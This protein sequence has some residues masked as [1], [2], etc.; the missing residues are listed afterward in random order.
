MHKNII[1]INRYF[2]KKKPKNRTRNLNWPYVNTIDR[3]IE[4][5]NKTKSDSWKQKSV[6]SC[7]VSKVRFKKVWDVQVNKSSKMIILSS[8]NNQLSYIYTTWLFNYVIDFQ[9]PFRNMWYTLRVSIISV[10]TFYIMCII[11]RCLRDVLLFLSLHLRYHLFIVN[12]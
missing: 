12:G 9:Y 1:D 8:G 3:E 6:A 4:I 2:N 5:S 11:Y 10:Y 7:L